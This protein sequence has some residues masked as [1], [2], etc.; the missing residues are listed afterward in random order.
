MTREHKLALIV[1]FSLV[2]VLGVLISDHFSK[3]RTTEGMSDSKVAQARDVGAVPPGIRLAGNENALAPLPGQSTFGAGQPDTALPMVNPIAAQPQPRPV[4]FE[5]VVNGA[6][7][8][9]ADVPPELARATQFVPTNSIDSTPGAAQTPPIGTTVIMG[10][11]NGGGVTPGGP[12]AY[13]QIPVNSPQ[14]VIADSRPQL[15][16]SSGQMK[17]HDIREGDSLY[18]LARQTYGDGSLWEKL[19][20]FNKGKIGSGGAV[21]EGV[22]IMLPPKDV[23]LGK[24]VMPDARA[25]TTTPTPITPTNVRPG[26]QPTTPSTTTTR[27]EQ[28]LASNTNFTTYTVKKGDILEDIARR[29]LGSSRRWSEIVDANKSVISDPESIQVG[30][31]LRIPAR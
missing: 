12:T 14:P 29:T 6:E 23:L 11:P 24:A 16:V 15:P 4:E 28:R 8:R 2:L 1:G 5:M 21:R 20:D 10:T 17:R 13:T 22:T 30:M 18:S 7:H 26:A 3:S 19:K 9:Q 27:P 25:G 31:T